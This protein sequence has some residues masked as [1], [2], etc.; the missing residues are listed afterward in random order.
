M[1]VESRGDYK[2]FLEVHCKLSLLRICRGALSSHGIMYL[3]LCPGKAYD[4]RFIHVHLIMYR[5]IYD[6]NF[7][8]CFMFFFLRMPTCHFRRLNL[9]NGS[10]WMAAVLWGFPALWPALF[11]QSLDCTRCNIL[12]PCP[13]LPEGTYVGA[14]DPLARWWLLSSSLKS[15]PVLS[16][17]CRYHKLLVSKK[18]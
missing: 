7:L 10:L 13:S 16:P 17:M 11:F 8:L 9:S 3:L 18:S 6:I 15:Y 1:C 12:F 5:L 4:L 2:Y 14:P